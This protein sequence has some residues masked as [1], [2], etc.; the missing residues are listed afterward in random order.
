MFALSA[1]STPP[2]GTGDAEW[3]AGVFAEVESANSTPPKGTGDAVD[4]ARLRWTTNSCPRTALRR[5]ALVTHPCAAWESFRWLSCPRT[6]LR[7]KALVTHAM[8]ILCVVWLLCPRTA[9]R[10]KALVTGRL[11]CVADLR[12]TVREQHSAERHW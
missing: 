1:N 7:R 3:H 4:T 12:I 2:K 8:M 10:R 6:A 5:K 9:L 11:E